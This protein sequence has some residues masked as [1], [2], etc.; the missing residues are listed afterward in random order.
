[1]KMFDY[2]KAI[3]E[4]S[5]DIKIDECIILKGTQVK[6]VYGHG[7]KIYVK[8]DDFGRGFTAL[9]E[10]GDEEP[11]PRHDVDEWTRNPHY[12]LSFN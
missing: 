7:E 3:D 8:W 10:E 1:M 6:A 11:D 12:D 9:R 4:L 2:E 5:T